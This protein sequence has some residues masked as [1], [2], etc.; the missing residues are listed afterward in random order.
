MS[1]IIL[2]GVIVPSSK[3]IGL[4][5]ES[6]YKIV[7]AN[8][9]EYFF[10]PDPDWDKILSFY[11]WQD[12]RVFGVVDRS[13]RTIDPRRIFPKG[14]KGEKEKILSLVKSKIN[15]LVASPIAVL[16]VMAT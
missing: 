10:L 3:P 6:K 2:S 13:L 12:V 7:C 14:P 9:T 5:R 15:D 8:G 1:A 11:S 16:A 4:D